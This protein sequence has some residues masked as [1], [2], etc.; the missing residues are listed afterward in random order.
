MRL[1]AP[2]C[3][4]LLPVVCNKGTQH[5]WKNYPSGWDYTLKI[6]ATEIQQF[7]STILNT[8]SIGLLRWYINIK[9][10]YIYIYISCIN[11]S[12][13]WTLLIAVFYWKLD[14]VGFPYLIGNILRFPYEPN[15][16]MLPIGL[17]RW[18]INVTIAISY[19]IHSPV[20]HLK[21]RRFGDWFLSPSSVEPN[22]SGEKDRASF[23][24][25]TPATA[26]T[27]IIKAT[28]HKPPMIGVE[29]L[30]RFFDV[31][32]LAGVRRQRLVPSLGP[33]WVGS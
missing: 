4:V 3:C 12:Q 29:I 8:W 6:E 5:S 25:R 18:Y 7:S 32:V 20:F 21:S 30:T 13:F 9:M 11:I 1:C 14:S 23:S 24:F 26:P 17:W 16:L 31:G 33:N 15:R 28:Q 22:Q 10:P 19:V 27:V 2:W